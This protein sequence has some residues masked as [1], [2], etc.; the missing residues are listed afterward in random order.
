MSPPWIN[1]YYIMD[2]A[3]GRSFVEWA[4]RHGHQTFMISYRNPDESMR[5]YT[6]DTYLRLGPIAALDAVQR[7]T[8]APQVNMAALCLGGTMSVLLLAYLAAKGEAHRVSSLTMTNTIVDFA[9]PGDLGVFTDETTIADLERGMSERGF[10]ESSE[11]AGTFNWMRANDLVWSYVVSN[12]YMGKK[13]PAFD[14]LAWNS[15]TTRMPAAMHSQYLRSCYLHNLLV[16]PNAFVHRRRADRLRHGRDAAVRPRRRSRSHRAVAHDVYHVPARRRR[17]VKYTRTNSGHVA[18]ICNP[19]RQESLLLDE[20]PHRTGESADGWMAQRRATT[21]AGG[22]IGPLGPPPTRA[23]SVRR[24]TSRAGEPAPGPLRSQ[25]ERRRERSGRARN[26]LPR[27]A[28]SRRVHRGQRELANL[29]LRQLADIAKVSNPYLSQVERGLYKP[30]AE[31]LKNLASALKISA[32]TMY[33]QAGLLD[34]TAAQAEPGRRGRPRGAP[35]GGR[36]SRSRRRSEPTL[37]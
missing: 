19:R 36:R 9:E 24:T 16:V 25:R 17:D 12:W 10:L 8:G 33:T 20:G 11:M 18:G 1:K 26:A 5:D 34:A 21:E 23:Q 32:E 3:P 22:K 2:L 30:S 7:L 13:P 4:V 28:Q 6:M 27:Q 31:V 37:A 35:A 15:D 14:I 29:S